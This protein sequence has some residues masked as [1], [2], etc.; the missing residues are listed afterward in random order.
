MAYVGTKNF[1]SQVVSDLEKMTE[2]YGLRVGQA[3][4]HE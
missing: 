4:E 1:P 2:D 3:I